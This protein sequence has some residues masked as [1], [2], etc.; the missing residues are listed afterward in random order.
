LALTVPML[1]NRMIKL[2]SRG[3]AVVV[4]TFAGIVLGLL[5]VFDVRAQ[6]AD[7]EAAV[8]ELRAGYRAM[9]PS[10]GTPDAVLA[11]RDLMLPS[12]GDAPAIPAR[13]YVPETPA[14]TALLP[15]VIYLHGGGWAS[16]DFDTH[17][18]MVRAL[19]NRSGALVVAVSYRLAPENP[20]PAGLDD[21]HAVASW[22]A[23]NAA[24]IGGDA[25]RLA[26]SGD[27][28]AARLPPALAAMLRDRGGPQLRAQLLLYPNVGNAMDTDSWRVL[29]GGHFP[30]VVDMQRALQF[31]LAEGAATA[32]DPRVSPLEGDLRGLPPTLVITAG[33]DPLK[34]EGRAYALKLRAAGGQAGFVEYPDAAHGFVQ[35]FKNRTAN[36]LGEEAIDLGAAFLRG[37]LA[38]SADPVSKP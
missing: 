24:E 34:D 3:S 35:F 18:V 36:P 12:R 23:A 8:R 37:R 14:G 20:F 31:Y 27:S 17:D 15:V 5:Q 19:A 9:I 38:P 21:C 22:L 4:W 13:V 26:V 25:T 28:A 29:G 16:G 10:A 11:V 32:R 30:T 7:I 6:N 33:N 1:E 2:S